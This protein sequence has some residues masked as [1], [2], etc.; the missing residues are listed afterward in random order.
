MNI[1]SDSIFVNP[2]PYTSIVDFEVCANDSAFTLSSGNPMGGIYSGLGISNGIFDPSFINDSSSLYTYEY[3]DSNNCTSIDSAFIHINSL[4]NVQ[5]LLPNDICP[6]ASVLNLNG[7]SPFE[8]HTVE[9][10]CWA[11]ILIPV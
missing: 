3:S 5:L 8:V 11:M 9:L 4:P 6:N 1:I 2:P 10:E 7:G